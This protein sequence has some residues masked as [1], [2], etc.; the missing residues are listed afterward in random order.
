MGSL[1]PLLPDEAD[2]P[3]I[4]KVDADDEIILWLN[5]VSPHRTV[6]ELTDYT[7]RNLVDRFSTI[8]GVARVRL[9]GGQRY[10]MRIWLDRVAL[11]A[12]QLTVAN[13]EQALQRENVELPAGSIDSQRMQLPLRV[14]RQFQS[15]EDFKQLV[16]RTDSSGY[17]IRF[18]DVARVERG[19]EEDRTLF[20]GNGVPMVGIG[21]IK[22]S[23]ANTIEVARA[24]K[25]LAQRLASEIPADI[26]IRQSFDSSVF[27]EAAIREVYITLVIAML[28]VG[29]VLYGSLGSWRATLVPAVTVPGSV[30]LSCIFLDGLGLSLN[31]FTALALVLAIGL[32]VDDAIVVVENIVRRCRELGESVLVASYRG[33]REVTFAVIATTVVLLSVFAPLAYI[34]GDIG[35]LFSEFAITMAVAVLMSSILALTL[36][37]VIAA[38][39]VKKESEDGWIPERVGSGVLWPRDRYVAL[40]DRLL[41]RRKRAVGFVILSIPAMWFMMA[42]LPREY[43]PRENR[44]AFF[45][46]IQGPEGASHAYMSAHMDEIERRLLPYVS[47]G[48]IERLLIR[49]PRS[50]GVS[51]TFNDGNVKAVL[52]P[53]GTRPSA[54][55]IMG[56]IRKD[57]DTLPGVRSFPVMRQGF[58]GG[59]Q[60]PVRFV[61][62]GGTYSELISW[63]DILLKKL[64]EENP[65][66]VGIDWDYKE[67]TPQLRVAID[68]TK[69]AELGL[70]L[71]DIGRTLETMLAS[72]RITT[73][74]EEG[75][76]YDVILEGE[77]YQQRAPSDVQNLFIRSPRTAELIPR[78]TVTTLEEFADSVSLNRYNRKRAITIDAS[79]EEHLSLGSAL[80]YLEELARSNLPGTVT[81][82]YKGESL[83]Y[84]TGRSD[85]LFIFLL[86]LVTVYLVL[87]AQ[88]ESF[89]HPLVIMLSVPLTVL[90]GLFAIWISGETLN[91]YSQVALVMLVG[92]AAKNGILL[93]EFANQLRDG[94]TDFA[95]AVRES[96]RLRF[97]PIFMTSVTT[98]FGA[99]P[100][101][102]ATGAGSETR[103]AI[104]VALLVEL[105]SARL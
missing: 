72:R 37:P 11:A 56:A 77:R 105:C 41:L 53:W 101:V 34:E 73:F 60:K 100:L 95:V 66:F 103:V 48:E 92:L 84:V 40:L 94:G 42:S 29:I 25:S 24:A 86:G 13:V 91:L 102:L 18:G 17:L 33:T 22:Q 28:L 26:E 69:A 14:E 71:S 78:S 89:V 57:L 19:T 45:V 65:G 82:D 9:G 63:R 35:R 97:R 50:F 87:A 27:I 38:F 76:E 4:R 36:C 67:T 16:L 64:Q 59:A 70:S 85:I 75:E 79:L 43:T 30:I 31:L 39:I 7:E 3:E 47:S 88:F 44:G 6:A 104:G 20:R 81:I 52:A 10:A 62:G 74:I 1:M 80:G 99:I 12:R 58:R 46:Q 98:L 49:S 93:V 68:Y 61:I 51:L 15:T 55:E 96:A 32:V 21:I 2:P 90:G 23:T 54:W 5:V 83:Q 8:D